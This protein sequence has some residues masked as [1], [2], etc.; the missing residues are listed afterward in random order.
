M[1]AAAGRDIVRR[2]GIMAAGGGPR[3]GAAA[4]TSRSP[5]A[6]PT[7][8]APIPSRDLYYARLRAVALAAACLF[9][10]TLAF[11]HGV[12]L[13][14][15]TLATAAAFAF[16]GGGWRD[17]PELP[18]RYAWLAWASVA[19]LSVVFAL[20]RRVSLIE[21]RHEILYDFAMFATWFT[22]ARHADGGQWL[23][24]TLAVTAAVV[25]VLGTVMILSGHPYFELGAYGDVGS[26]STWLVS[27]LPLFLLLSLRARP[28][29]LARAGIVMLA[30][31][32]LAAG[33][34]TLNRVFGL[35]A[36]AEIIVF[37]LLTIRSW[38]TSRRS[39]WMIGI[40]VLAIGL[41]LAS[42]PLATETR[43]ALS[44]P[45]TDLGEFLSGDP[46]PELWRFALAQIAEHPWLGNGLGK[47][48]S[49]ALFADEF[50]D[51]LR[52]HAHNVFLNRALETGLPGLAAFVILM[53]SVVVAFLRMVRSGEPR[54]VDTGAAGLAL[55]VGV[56][57]KNLTD[58]FFVGQNAL[59][60]WSLTGAALGVAA[61]RTGAQVAAPIGA[62][63]TGRGV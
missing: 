10:V 23:G 18:L 24:R 21:F 59:L 56:L 46:R 34:L 50:H 7:M 5:G 8:S 45:G 35:A 54:A 52:L 3:G 60:F 13:R 31:G 25:L 58:D 38:R 57:L 20:D 48:T 27:V 53:A 14:V 29:S 49:R 12:T 55:V 1:N 26:L 40:G 28:R 61:R 43:I 47:W 62:G 42:I 4:S 17:I 11:H 32:C 33:F 15:I 6:L 36:A 16:A 2:S 51:V 39:A 37:S 30:A 44:A 9:V 19:A 41:A 22:L 63:S